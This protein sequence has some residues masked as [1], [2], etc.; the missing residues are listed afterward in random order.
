MQFAR[1]LPSIVVIEL[2]ISNGLLKDMQ[3]IRN[4]GEILNKELERVSDEL[5]RSQPARKYAPTE[6]TEL[7]IVSG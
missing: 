5:N 7:G 1:K 2:G 4:P 6:L 3:E